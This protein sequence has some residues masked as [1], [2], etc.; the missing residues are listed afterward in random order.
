VD[1]LEK[2]VPAEIKSAATSLGGAITGALGA[3]AKR[4]AGSGDVPAA[5]GPAGDGAKPGDQGGRKT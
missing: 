5:G 4:V 3:V 2:S 1:G